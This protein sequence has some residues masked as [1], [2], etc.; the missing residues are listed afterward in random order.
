MSDQGASHVIV[1]GFMVY[2]VLYQSRLI[3]RWISAWGLIAIAMIAIGARLGPFMEFALVLELVLVLPI[4]VQEM[5]M[6]LWL[7]VKGWNPEAIE[8]LVVERESGQIDMT[9][10]MHPT[11]T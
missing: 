4:A 5:V 8:P 2:T 1:G 3:P 7:I 6:A 11:P 10:R 9:G